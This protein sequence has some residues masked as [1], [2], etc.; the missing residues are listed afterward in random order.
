MPRFPARLHVLLAL[1]APVGLVIRRGPSKSV[2]TLLWNRQTDEFELGQWLRGRIYERRCDLSPDGKHFLHFA[3]NGKL[4]T[5]TG[6]SWTSISR[7]PY[8]KADI[9][10]AKGD[11]WH[12]GGLFTKNE[13]YWLNDGA[14]HKLLWDHSF[15]L[16][17]DKRFKPAEYFGGECPGVYYPRLIRD[18]WTFTETQELGRFQQV[19]IFDKP[20][21]QGWTLRKLAHAE[22]GSPPGKGCYWDEHV[23]LHPKTN[24]SIECPK[25]EWADIDGNRLVWAADGRLEAGRLSAKGI[26]DQIVLHDFNAM[27]FAAIKAPY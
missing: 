13:K 17:R 24:L 19:T 6:G 20:V 9:L 25:W 27:E 1:D 15:S 12:G 3:M 16:T 18:G 26:V 5:K 7:A 10:F 8:L 11:C 23:L 14:G 22:L 21:T 2:A 4:H